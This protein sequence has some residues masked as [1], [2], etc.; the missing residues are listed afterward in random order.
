MILSCILYFF[1]FVGRLS[2]IIY[3]VQLEI[4]KE[5]SHFYIF[6]RL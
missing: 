4:R 1:I 6:V 3:L 5:S 2:W